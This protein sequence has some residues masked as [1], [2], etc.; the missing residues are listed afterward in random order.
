MA[1][2][3]NSELDLERLELQ[4]R[5]GERIRTRRL[6]RRCWLILRTGKQEREDDIDNE[7]LEL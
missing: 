1:S 6:M 4:R 2:N 5:Y 7:I 3:N